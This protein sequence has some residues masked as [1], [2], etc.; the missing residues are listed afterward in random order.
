M[1]RLLLAFD[2]A[3]R[4]MQGVGVDTELDVDFVVEVDGSGL[5]SLTRCAML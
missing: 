1:A 3:Y 4:E 2:A 5:F